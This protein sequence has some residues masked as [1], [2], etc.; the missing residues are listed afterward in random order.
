MYEIVET[1]VPYMYTNDEPVVW[2]SS[3]TSV[4]EVKLNH[5]FTINFCMAL[6]S[7]HQIPWLQ[8]A[9]YQF[10]LLLFL[11]NTCTTFVFFKL[12][13]NVFQNVF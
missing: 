11:T 12:K 13:L 9:A 4:N 5:G 1:Y 2:F 6:Y 8:P 7:Y 10:K 3:F